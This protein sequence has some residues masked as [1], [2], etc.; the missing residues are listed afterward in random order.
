[1]LYYISFN[2]TYKLIHIS[3]CTLHGKI[4]NITVYYIEFILLLDSASQ[5]HYL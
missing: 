2:N 3:C 5:F 1:M 4:K